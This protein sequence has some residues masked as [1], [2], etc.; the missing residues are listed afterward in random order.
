M[1]ELIKAG[2]NVNIVDKVSCIL[3]KHSVLTHEN[4][5]YAIIQ[6]STHAVMKETFIL[7]GSI[8]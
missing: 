3:S 4:L 8:L 5:H 1:E 7:E 2:A 6:Y